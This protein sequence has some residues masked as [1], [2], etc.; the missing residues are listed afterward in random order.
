M[1]LAPV[2]KGARA[3]TT[4]WRACSA[5]DDHLLM[6]G[7]RQHTGVFTQG[8]GDA[9]TFSLQLRGGLADAKSRLTLPTLQ[10]SISLQWGAHYLLLRSTSI[11]AADLLIPSSQ[12][13]VQ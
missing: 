11:V 4:Y 13:Q 5:R 7:I 1:G 6:D 12:R 2:R 3:P 8:A 10:Q 9:E